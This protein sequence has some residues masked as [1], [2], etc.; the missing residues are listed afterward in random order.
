MLDDRRGPQAADLDRVD[1]NGV[2]IL[3]IRGQL[4][5][6]N[7]ASLKAEV[8]ALEAAR[9]TKVLVDLRALTHLDSSGVGALMALFKRLGGDRGL[10]YF[11]GA[12]DQPAYILKVV[13]F[14]NTMALCETVEDALRRLGA[15]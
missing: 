1:R 6:E 15:P 7:S 9:A 4:V 5:A 2:T 3:A 12:K 14:A 13:G 11:A 10:V 8:V